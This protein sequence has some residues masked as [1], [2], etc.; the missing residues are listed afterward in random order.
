MRAPLWRAWRGEAGA[1]SPPMLRAPAVNPA[2][3]AI[4]E[5]ITQDGLCDHHEPNSRGHPRGSGTCSPTAGSTPSGSS[6][7]QDESRPSWPGLGARTYH[8]LGAW[9][10]PSRGHHPRCSS[11]KTPN[12]PRL[13]PMA[14]RPAPPCQQVHG[15][16]RPR[17][18]HEHDR[19]RGVRL[20]TAGAASPCATCSTGGRAE[21]YAASPTSPRVAAPKGD[22]RSFEWPATRT[23]PR[24]FPTSGRA[25]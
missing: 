19:R 13:R 11:P 6:G 9:P 21:R 18:P 5:P 16:P 24:A 12:V 15:G 4:A 17:H 7:I 23:A 2:T 8:S 10:G 1:E 25:C 14:G 20:P 3:T 22:A